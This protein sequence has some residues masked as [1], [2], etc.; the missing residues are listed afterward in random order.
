MIGHYR[1]LEGQGNQ[2][3]KS[4]TI[5]R[6]KNTV[7]MRLMGRGRQTIIELVNITPD[8]AE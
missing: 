5:T 2:E 7:E 6:H 1:I 8:E 3:I 4:Y